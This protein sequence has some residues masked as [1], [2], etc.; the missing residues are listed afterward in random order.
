MTAWILV[1]DTTK[2][3]IYT[4]ELPEQ[5]WTLVS[6]FEHPE[7]RESSREIRPSSPPGRMQS[8][9]LGGRRTAVEPRTTPK[10]AEAERFAKTLADHLQSAIARRQFDHLTIVAGA[11]FLG[12]LLH[13]VSD[14]VTKHLKATV[15]KDLVALDASELRER[16]AETVFSPK[17][18]P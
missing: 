4:T 2:A 17:S 15:T 12:L 14:Q 6:E 1:G 10:E 7:G 16:L 11:H 5:P 9:A 3:R 18:S 13:T 8:T